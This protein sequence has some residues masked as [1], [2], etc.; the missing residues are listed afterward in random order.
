MAYFRRVRSEMATA[1]KA[2][3]VGFTDRQIAPVGRTTGVWQSGD[4]PAGATAFRNAVDDMKSEGKRIL[5][6]VVDKD[7]IVTR[8]DAAMIAREQKDI[9]QASYHNFHGA[10]LSARQIKRKGHD[11]PLVGHE[12]DKLIQRIEARVDGREVG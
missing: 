9:L 1:P 11:D 7:G 2:A 4:E 12:G 8:S 3:T 10:A 5:K 6:R